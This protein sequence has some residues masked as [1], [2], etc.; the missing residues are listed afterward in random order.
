MFLKHKK[1]NFKHRKLRF[2]NGNFPY[3]NSLPFIVCRLK[4]KETMNIIR[5]I[6]L[7]MIIAAITTHYI[8]ENDLTD[9][10]SGFLIGGGIALLI[11]GKTIFSNRN[12]LKTN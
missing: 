2:T 9:F 6:G 5:I 12:K 7:I 8:M 10:I 4:I 1:L 3:I 11:T